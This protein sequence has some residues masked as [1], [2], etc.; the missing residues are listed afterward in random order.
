MTV[1]I[2]S[3]DVIS[4]DTF[5][6]QKSE[7]PVICLMGPNIKYEDNLNIH[8]SFYVGMHMQRLVISIKYNIC[9][10]KYLNNQ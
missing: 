2:S 6:K 5:L 4:S 8:N 1:S 9:S 10:L 3:H 7:P